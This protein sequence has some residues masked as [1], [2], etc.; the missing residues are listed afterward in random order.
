MD[1]KSDDVIS[2]SLKR[3]RAANRI[4]SADYKKRKQDLI[5]HLEKT[6][7]SKKLENGDLELVQ[8]KL[9]KEIFLLEYELAKHVRNKCCPIT[10]IGNKLIMKF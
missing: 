4:A 1:N 2:Q 5:V 3:K 7:K 8:E 6:V 10:L 9:K